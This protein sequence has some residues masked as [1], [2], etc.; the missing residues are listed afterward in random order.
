MAEPS[1]STSTPSDGSTDVFLNKVLDA[2]FAAALKE[3]SVTSNSVTLLNVATNSLVDIDIQYVS[4]TST[5]RVTPLSVLAENSVYRLRFIGTDSAISTSYALADSGGDILTS[6]ITVTFTTGTKVF[7]DDTSIDKNATDLSLEGDLNL[8]VHVK[9]LGELAVKTTYPLNHA[10]D[11]AT[12]LNGA[13]QLS[14]TF[15]KPLSGDLCDSS[16]LTVDVYSMLDSDQYLASDGVFGAGSI[17]TMTGLICSGATIYAGFNAVLPNNA[18]VEVTVGTGI[19]A[20]DGSEYGTNDYLFS[21]TT[22]RYPKVSGVHVIEREIKAATEQL[23]RD[24]VAALLLANTVYFQEKFAITIGTDP[25]WVQLRWVMLRT[26]VDILDDKELEKAL[27]DGTRRQLGD[28]NVSI[29]PKQSEAARLALK[30][31]RALKELDKLERTQ[32]GRRLLAMRYSDTK[33]LNSY[34]DRVWHGVAGKLLNTR[35]SN[36][37]PNMPVSNIS[38]NRQTKVGPEN[39]WY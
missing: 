16:W 9:A 29:D 18:G 33:M 19:V 23:N 37:Q 8:P 2:T 11:V 24:Y 13:N 7:I 34:P 12:G 36:Y 25:S 10:Y 15:N 5:I 26:I 39:P 35:W 17:P 20:S 31:A 28:L 22:D 27:V 14:V 21:F 3:S 4:S 38:V 1:L 32:G 6:T 30:H